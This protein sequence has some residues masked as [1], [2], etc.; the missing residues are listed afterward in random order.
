MDDMYA[1][2]LAKS[3]FREGFNRAD[4]EMVLS[5]YDCSFCDMS[6]GLP[7]FYDSGARDVFRARLQRLFRDYRAEMAVL[8]IK[9]VLHGDTAYDWG[10]H[11]L[12]LSDQLSGSLRQVRTRYFE[13]WRRDTDLGWVITSFIDNLDEAPKMPEEMI[14]EMQNTTSDARVTRLR[15]NDLQ[16]SGIERSSGVH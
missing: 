12:N 11:V 13:T 16:F 15:E 6:F 1:I 8:I 9:I 3:R 10:W 7:S 14:W 5:V 2:N 4:E